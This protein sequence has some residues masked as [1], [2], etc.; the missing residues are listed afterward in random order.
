L[1]TNRTAAIKENKMKI[2][3]STLMRWAGLSATLAG[4]S[5]LLVA[6]F[7]FS[8]GVWLVVKGFNPSAITSLANTT[9]NLAAE[10]LVP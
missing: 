1:N 3:T 2:T 8:L 9:S 4:L 10:P 5:A 7:E 6:L